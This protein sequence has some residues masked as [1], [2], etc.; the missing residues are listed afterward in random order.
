[1]TTNNVCSLLAGAS[2]IQMTNVRQACVDFLNSSL[3][4][5]TCLGIQALADTYTCSDLL[6]LADEYI[7]QHFGEVASTDE[8]LR[9]S[10][11]RLLSLLQRE[12]LRV[13]SE[14]QVFEAA[15]RWVRA[16]LDEREQWLPD[17]LS[18]VRLPLLSPQY[19]LD[20]VAP[21]PLIRGDL[22][23]RDLLD[24]AKDYH[25]VPERRAR[26]QTPRTVPRRCSKENGLIY[27]VGGLSPS[28]ESMNCVERLIKARVLLFGKSA[29]FLLCLGWIHW[30]L[31]GRWL[32]QCIL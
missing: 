23:C 13:R 32:R 3:R 31:N 15:M 24:E 22:R 17:V 16:D 30:T 19:L 9:L 4:P 7:Y 28:G 14:E 6:H 5:S 8:Y 27:A 1:M 25:L 10:T 11:D 26:M 2:L 20:H 21:D 12:E 18:K 29:R